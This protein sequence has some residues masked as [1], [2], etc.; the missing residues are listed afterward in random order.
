MVCK[1]NEVNLYMYFYKVAIENGWIWQRTWNVNLA[2][3]IFNH[4]FQLAPQN[5][6]SSRSNKIKWG[7]KWKGWMSFC[8]KRGKQVKSF[9]KFEVDAGQEVVFIRHCLIFGVY[10]HLW[11]MM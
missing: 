5:F 7:T 9:I 11:V 6:Y 10:F 2:S 1:Y 8:Q 4:F 3:T